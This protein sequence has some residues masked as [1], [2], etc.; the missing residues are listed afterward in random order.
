M[1]FWIIAFLL[2][3]AVAATL[4]MP[5]LR[6]RDEDAM[7]GYEDVALY[8]QQLL[9]IERDLERGV[10]DADEAERTRTEIARRLIAADRATPALRPEAPRL[11]SLLTGGVT[12]AIVIGGSLAVYG[13]I[14]APGARDEPRT[15]RLAEGDALRDTRMTQDEAEANA[16][17]TPA[18]EQPPPPADVLQSVKNLRASLAENPDDLQAWQILTD[19]ETRTGNLPAAVDAMTNVVRIKGDQATIT[20]L[21]GLV[22]RMVFATQGIV[23]PEAEAVLDRMIAIDPGNLAVRYYM[24]LLYATTDRPDLAFALWREVIEQGGTSMHANL[25]RQGIEDVAYMSGRDYRPP[26]LPG[27]TADDVANAEEM[28]PEDRLT[29]IRGMVAQL[30]DRLANEG[31]SAEE[32]ARLISSYGVLGETDNAKAIWTEAQSVFADSPAAMDTLRAAA[33][34]AGVLE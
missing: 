19:F 17:L 3:L 30:N 16:A 9:E 26:A 23:T 27:P 1:L 13:T 24:G 25:A 21:T 14:G 28:A 22:D 34:Q 29:M 18:P 2:A 33:A 32:W 8:R 10:L 31:G 5:L 4:A 15:L 7:T 6:P 20:D 12:L 11:P